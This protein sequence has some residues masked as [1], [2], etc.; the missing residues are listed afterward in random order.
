MKPF[1]D[2]QKLD[3]AWRICRGLDRLETPDCHR[4]LQQGR[5][6]GQ[7]RSCRQHQ[8]RK[9]ARDLQDR[10]ELHR[11]Q[12]VPEKAKANI[13]MMQVI[14]IC[15]AVGNMFK[16]PPT[17]LEMVLHTIFRRSSNWIRAGIEFDNNATHEQYAVTA[18]V[19]AHRAEVC[20]QRLVECV[21]L[22][23][24]VLVYRPRYVNGFK[25]GIRALSDRLTNDGRDHTRASYSTSP[26]RAPAHLPP[27][28]ELKSPRSNCLS[29]L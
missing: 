25:L 26:L 12:A 17:F 18:R 3:L 24:R 23:L 5:A 29:M 19:I 6:R 1:R 8:H 10:Q 28:A 9:E 22:I 15:L 16:F 4:V 7:E 13:V 11:P 14:A 2:N 20:T 27:P 21:G